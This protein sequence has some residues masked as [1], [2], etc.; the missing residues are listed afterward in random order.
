MTRKLANAVERG[1]FS[2]ESAREVLRIT[3]EILRASNVRRVKDGI[4]GDH[5]NPDSFLYELHVLTSPDQAVRLN[6]ELADRIVARSDLMEDPGL[7]FVPV[8]IGT[9]VD[10][11]H[12]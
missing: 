4:L 3:H 9:T 5:T 10:A 11:D 8:F 6:E 2:E 1:A 7:K 12:T